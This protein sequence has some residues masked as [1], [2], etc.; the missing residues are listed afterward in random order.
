MVSGM[1]IPVRGESCQVWTP[2]P[3]GAEADGGLKPV[4][5]GETDRSLDHS[6]SAFGMHDYLNGSTGF[7]VATMC[8]GMRVAKCFP[9]F[10]PAL[11]S[12][13]SAF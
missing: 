10:E 13:V 5:G 6:R 11:R 8:T 3:Q 4:S 9:M 12:A 7:V 2:V 1:A